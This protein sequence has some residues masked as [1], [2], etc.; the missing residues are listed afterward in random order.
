VAAQKHGS[1]ERWIAIAADIGVVLGIVVA[2]GT[3]LAGKHDTEG[4]KA[5]DAALQFSALR[6]GS[7]YAEASAE[8]LDVLWKK[9]DLILNEGAQ[10]EA[11]QTDAK[12]VIKILGAGKIDGLAM[13]YNSIIS[14]EQSLV[15]DVET[16]K[17]LFDGDIRS[18]YCET[19]GDILPIILQRMN[20][21]QRYD[22]LKQYF[23]KTI[24]T[25]PKA[26]DLNF[27]ISAR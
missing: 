16:S 24:K 21:P 9:G 17:T 27:A 20:E 14:C 15:C 1:I 13:L 7:P 12:N 18:F 10:N 19:K 3:Y 5:R 6:H 11:R 26:V 25:C 8:L 23:A 2:A 22:R 4:A